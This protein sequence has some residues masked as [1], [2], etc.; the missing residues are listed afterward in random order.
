MSTARSIDALEATASALGLDVDAADD[1]SRFRAAAAPR[2]RCHALVALVTTAPAGCRI[3]SCCGAEHHGRRCPGHGSGDTAGGSHTHDVSFTRR[4]YVHEQAVP[5]D[6]VGELRPRRRVRPTRFVDRMREPGRRRRTRRDSSSRAPRPDPGWQTDGDARRRGKRAAHAT[7]HAARRGRRARRETDARL[8]HA[9]ADPLSAA[10]EI[11]SIAGRG[12]CARRTTARAEAGEL[13]MRGAVLIKVAG[14]GARPGRSRGAAESSCAAALER[15]GAAPRARTAREQRARGAALHPRAARTP[16]MTACRCG[17]LSGRQ[18]CCARALSA[19]GGR[20]TPSGSSPRAAGVP[21]RRTS[22][23]WPSRSW[24]WGG[25][26]R[27]GC[28]AR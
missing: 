5:A 3:S 28:A 4:L 23:G 2:R 14:I 15:A 8:Q 21:A 1:A 22:C 12:R 19:A 20:L 10:A 27:S 11:P 6:G 17:P 7:T 13:L 25:A 18:R 24:R 9:V 16:G 26:S